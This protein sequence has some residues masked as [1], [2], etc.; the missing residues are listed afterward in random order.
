MAT[1]KALKKDD[2]AASTSVAV[3]KNTSVVSIKDQIAAQV[4]ALGDR[5][6]PPGGS[7]IKLANGSMTLPDGTK[8]PG[9]L[10]V[11]V[12]DFVAVNKF[13]EGAYDKDNITPPACFAIGSN[14]AK[15]VP[16]PNAPLPQ[17]KTCAECPM[18]AF[19]SS[20]KGKAC[21]NERL[22]AVL[23]PDGADDTP[24]WTLGVSPTGIKGFDGYVANVARTFN[25]VPVGV[26][27]T[28]SLD[29]NVDYP[30]LRFGD[31]V[32]NPGLG[33]HFARQAEAK[34]MLAVEPDVSTFGAAKPAAKAAAKRPAVRR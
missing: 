17:A 22:L 33:T 8:T 4:A 5:I 10:E 23:P 14:P 9:P 24:L 7:K 28:V 2:G 29:P 27:T 16:S 15:L 25:T 34:A 19:G 32:P 21:K 26:V 12:V 11:V 6:A 20:G 31:P 3:R 30:S 13:Y 18:N 1:S